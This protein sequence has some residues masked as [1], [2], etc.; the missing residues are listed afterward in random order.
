VIPDELT[1]KILRLHFVEGWKVGTIAQQA[2]VHHST[3]R[4][5][6]E[7]NGI[8]PRLAVRPSIV[9][10]YLPFMEETLRRW[11]TLP[12]SRLYAM[13]VE[14]GYAG[15]EGHFRRIVSRMRP[16]PP[17]EAYLRLATLPG[18]QG[19][20][21]WA[22]CGKVD[23]GRATR[24]LSAFVLV[25]AWSRMPFVRFFYDQR[26]GS[27][28][29]GHQAAF[30]ALGGV[31]RTV[32]YDNLKAVVAERRGDAIRF[33]PT[34]L[35]FAGHHRFEPR[36][37]APY[38][39]NEKP[40]VERRIRDLRRSFLLGRSW[41]GLDELNE[42]VA[43][44][45]LRVA[46][47][48]RHPDDRTM[49]VAEAWEEEKKRLLPLPDDTFPAHDRVEVKVG[50]TPYVRFDLNDY[51]V[52]HD[53]VRRTLVVLATPEIIRVLDGEQEVARHQRSFDKGARIEEPKHVE[54][55]V[56]WK[57]KARAARGIDLLRLAV[58]SS[59]ALLEG[60]AKRGHNIGS[61]VAAMLRLLDS[62][63]AEALEVATREAIEADALHVGA[64]RQVLERRAQVEGTP[65]PLPVSLP[66][67]P[68][69]RD[70]H[71]RPHDLRTYDNVGGD[72]HDHA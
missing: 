33:N 4:R 40:R 26:L 9:D 58:P 25:L 31:P 65:P 64:V 32:L 71:V 44:W 14:R 8:A 42:A 22:H 28:M 39:G 45:C 72:H 41:S 37:V 27:F 34:F 63:G 13:V 52:P 66:D 69:V 67:D 53:H 62:W 11:P 23:V 15:A 46:G 61:A 6:L 5:V 51:S 2:G 16:R 38:R 24:P 10:P 21:D 36:P 49:T 56:A 48:R 55:L 30:E 50:R 57:R 19:Q 20:A 59:Q 43:E 17:A 7:S 35:S 18:E 60:A 68:R 1:Q 3:V 47:Q 54:D 70:V 12:A 29:A